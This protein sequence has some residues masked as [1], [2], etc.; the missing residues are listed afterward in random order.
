[1]HLRAVSG[2][3]LSADPSHS[4]RV[5][6]VQSAHSEVASIL[7][8]LRMLKDWEQ[9]SSRELRQILGS[10]S[11]RVRSSDPMPLCSFRS[12]KK[13]GPPSI[14]FHGSSGPGHRRPQVSPVVA[15]VQVRSQT[16]TDFIDGFERSLRI[17]AHDLHEGPSDARTRVL[18]LS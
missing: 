8:S 7:N 15:R 5:S 12:F 3:A 14:A 1:M 13:A 10:G 11:E 6:D 9:H 4:H 18:R 16:L 17:L 2:P